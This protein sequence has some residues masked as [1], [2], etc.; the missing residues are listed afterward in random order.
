MFLSL[1]TAWDYINDLSVPSVAIDMKNIQ[2]CWNGHDNGTRQWSNLST[3]GQLRTGVRSVSSS[4]KLA[5]SDHIVLADSTSGVVT[6]T[7]PT[8][9]GIKGQQYIVKRTSAGKNLVKILP[10]G[11]ETIDGGTA[12]SLGWQYHS[13]GV[14]S[15]GSNWM[16]LF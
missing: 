10:N 1:K 14:I 3:A 15:D 13:V 4:Y 11:S 16:V 7:L 9:K 5:F 12:Y 6:I 2:D 8:A